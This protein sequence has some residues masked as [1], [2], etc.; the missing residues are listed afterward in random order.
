MCNSDKALNVAKLI[1]ISG[2]MQSGGDDTLQLSHLAGSFYSE[3]H[4]KWGRFNLTFSF[5]GT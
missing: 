4:W 1:E 5:K 3:K 2:K